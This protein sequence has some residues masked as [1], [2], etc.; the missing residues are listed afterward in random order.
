[1][2]LGEPVNSGR[3][4]V[5]PLILA[6]IDGH[7]PEYLTLEEALGGGL[8]DVTESDAE[9]V[10]EISVTNRAKL[11]VLLVEGEQLIGAKQNRVLNITILVAAGTTTAVPVSC[12]ERGRWHYAGK[13][14]EFGASPHAMFYTAR[15][16]KV[17]SVKE[18]LRTSGAAESDQGMV[19]RMIDAKARRMEAPSPTG[20]MEAI[21][22]RHSLGVEEVLAPLRPVPGQ[23]GAMVAL[24]GVPLAAECFDRSSTWE[25]MWRKLLS[26][27]ALEAL[28]PTAELECETPVAKHPQELLQLICGSPVDRTHAT[29]LGEH[30]LFQGRLEGFAL[31]YEGRAVH[32]FASAH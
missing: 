19:W 31:C 13:G 16:A 32:L 29:G 5:H 26:G 22:D 23:V 4:T 18:S 14:R 24:D 25:R 2:Q 12:V 30:L 10:P 21:Y 7:K 15:R 17:R 8:I 9:T 28:D 11:P 3:L 20:A 6:A 1:V 27:C